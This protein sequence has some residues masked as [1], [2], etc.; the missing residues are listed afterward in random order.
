MYYVEDRYEDAVPI[1]AQLF[2]IDPT[3][4]GDRVVYARALRLVGRSQE[5]AQQE[6]LIEDSFGEFGKE[7]RALLRARKYA[8]AAS[9]AKTHLSEAHD[10]KEIRALVHIIFSIER[11]KADTLLGN[12]EYDAAAAAYAALYAVIDR[13]GEQERNVY[14]MV[15]NQRIHWAKER[16]NMT[17]YSKEVWRP[18]YE[19]H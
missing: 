13:L 4:T 15:L 16:K 5:A 9:F 6:G 8:E 14:E 10:A 1:Y 17:E 2:R 7:A 18:R 12:S 11:R 19:K 3:R